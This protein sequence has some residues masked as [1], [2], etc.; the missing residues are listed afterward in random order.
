MSVVIATYNCQQY[1]GAAIASVLAQTYAHLELHVVD[2]GSTDQTIMEVARFVD[3]PRVHYH[4]QANAGH[5]VAKNRGIEAS[6]GE[7]IGFCDADDL[8]RP[9]KL[10]LQLA[11]FAGND[12]VGVVYSRTALMNEH[13]APLHRDSA[14][15]PECPSGRV[16]DALFRINF[17]PFGTALVRRRC[18]D[19]HGLFEPRHGTSIDWE[20]WLRLSI[21]YEFEFV[22]QETHVYRVWPGQM[23]KNWQRLYDHAFGIMQGIRGPSSRRGGP[24]HRAR[25]LVPQLHAARPVAQLP[26]GRIRRWGS[27]CRAR[28]ANPSDLSTRVEDAARDCARRVRTPPDT[29]NATRPGMK[30]KPLLSIVIPLYNE[31]LVLEPLQMRMMALMNDP[32]FRWEVVMVND[33]STDRTLEKVRRLCQLD[34]RFRVI[35]FSRNFGHQIAITAGMDKAAGDAVVIIDADLQ[36]PPEVIP[37]MVDKWREGYDVVYGV[38]TKREGRRAASSGR[39]R[40]SSTACCNARP[41]RHPGRHGRFPPHGSARASTSC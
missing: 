17:I 6:R 13:G 7:F 35:S 9:E 23:S 30:L 39:P 5:A 28:A 10:A 37:Q 3:D 2:D 16:T 12:A 8:W 14:D 15:E 31:E 20:M 27:R 38:R 25:C 36:D 32:R 1:V 40:R 41:R 11:R 19:D 33:G 26:V 21:H 4:R 34:P 29:A 22:E 18:F 24:G